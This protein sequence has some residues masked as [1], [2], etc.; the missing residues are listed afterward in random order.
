VG[1]RNIARVWAVCEASQAGTWVDV[2]EVERG[3]RAAYQ[4]TLGA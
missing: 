3:A 1:T 4:Q 2:M